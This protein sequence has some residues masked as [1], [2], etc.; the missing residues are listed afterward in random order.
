STVPRTSAVFPGDLVQTRSDSMASIN[1]SG[2]SVVV[3]AD[4][5]VKFEGPAVGLEHGA[6]TVATSRGLGT[7]AGDVTVIPVSNSWTQ[8]EVKQAS[9]G[10]VQVVAQKGDVSVNDGS[11]TSTLAQGQQ[12]TVDNA[13]EKK[14][15]KR[16]KGGGAIPASGGAALDSP[17]VIYGGAAAVGGL[18]TWVLL[19]DSNPVSSVAP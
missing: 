18:L 15:K 11:T 7:H 19:Q 5:L 4:S 16:R 1:A 3:L 8:F 12:M 6:L 2:S 14:K 17:Y 13:V 10:T 9:D